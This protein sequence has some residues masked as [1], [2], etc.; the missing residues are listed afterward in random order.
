MW[1]VKP[2][3]ADTVLPPNLPASR[4]GCQEAAVWEDAAA[5]GRGYNQDM[6][7][8]APHLSRYARLGPLALGVLLLGPAPLFALLCRGHSPSRFETANLPVWERRTPPALPSRFFRLSPA[9]PGAVRIPGNPWLASL[10]RADEDRL[11]AGLERLGAAD[12]GAAGDWL[13]AACAWGREP[14]ALAAKQ[15]RVA[16]RLLAAQAEDGTFGPGGAAPRP[17]SPAEAAAQR[18]CLRGLLAYYAAAGRP[19]AI[20]AALAAGGRMAAAAK[21]RPDPAWVYPLARLSEETDDPRF[22]LAA[23]RQAALTGGSDNGDGLG[24]CALY[25]ATG[26]PEYLARARRAWEHGPRSPAL[27]AEML[28]LTGRPGYAAALDRLPP[29]GPE[30]A[31]AAWTRAPLGLAVNT[32]RDSAAVFHGLRLEQRTARGVRA[33]TVGTA[34]PTSARLRVFLPPGQPARIWI[35][36]VAQATPAPPGGYALLARRWRNGDRIEIGYVVSK[37]PALK[38][39][40]LPARKKPLHG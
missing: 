6:S 31:R 23:R 27:T 4:P 8:T 5:G 18:S 9:P 11:L 33:I 39:L 25:E 14:A 3:A 29:D 28:L 32:G 37:S 20:Q 7:R 10:L 38:G 24:L 36:G 21:G 2:L 34:A 30:T 35:N 22:L 12:A 1:V 17:W 13:E 26:Q 16:D 15:D 19:A 40:A